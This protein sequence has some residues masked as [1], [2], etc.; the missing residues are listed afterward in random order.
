MTRKELIEK[1]M[2]LAKQ[3]LSF[4]KMVI[5]ADDYTVLDSEVFDLDDEDFKRG[6]LLVIAGIPSSTIDEFYTNRISY[7][8]DKYKRIYKTIT[9]RAVLGIQAKESPY[10]LFYLLPSYIDLSKKER[11]KLEDFLNDEED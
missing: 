9:K 6:L 5:E 8:K 10:G 3:T 11:Y 1:F 2:I 4:A 7:T